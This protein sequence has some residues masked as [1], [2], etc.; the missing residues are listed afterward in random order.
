MESIFSGLSNIFF[1]AE[2]FEIPVSP[3]RSVVDSDEIGWGNEYVE[4]Y[5]I[6]GEGNPFIFWDAKLQ[7]FVGF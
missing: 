2:S 4:I 3:K 5:A 7:T 1:L 6:A